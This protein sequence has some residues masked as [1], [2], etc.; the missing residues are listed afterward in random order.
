[1]SLNMVH[2]TICEKIF[3]PT[4]FSFFYTAEL[5]SGVYHPGNTPFSQQIYATLVITLPELWASVLSLKGV[6]RTHASEFPSQNVRE[7]I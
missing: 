3:K 2:F 6:L 5:S 1:M 7:I 4:A